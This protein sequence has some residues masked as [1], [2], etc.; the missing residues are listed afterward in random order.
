M[1]AV[2]APELEGTTYREIIGKPVSVPEVMPGESNLEALDSHRR[3]AGL[4]VISELQ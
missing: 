4:P 3:W 2:V 1:T